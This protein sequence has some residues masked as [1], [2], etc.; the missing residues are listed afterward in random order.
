MMEAMSYNLVKCSS[1]GVVYITPSKNEPFTNIY[2]T[3]NK[4]AWLTIEWLSDALFKYVRGH[5]QE[6][7]DLHP[8]NRGKVI[9]Y[10][11][12]IQSSRWHRSYLKTPVRNTRHT[13]NSYMY[14]GLD[15]YDDL[16]LPQKFQPFLDFL[17]ETQ[18]MDKFNQVISNWYA[19]G[20]DYIAAH[21]D[22]RVDMK[23]DADIAILTLCAR[24]EDVRDLQF[25]SKNL[26]DV[27]NRAIYKKLN[28]Q[29]P[30]G[31]I[32]K[33][34]GDTQLKFRHMVP[35]APHISGSRISLTFRKF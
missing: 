29:T 14:S 6:L 20:H 4:S 11:Q 17:N 35:K 12:E 28:I 30:N 25:I 32:I 27:E 9:L 10:D 23:P 33:M 15:F 26:K 18:E 22:C 3:E 1:H 16:S 2:L 13:K 31:C 5:Y 24:E 19:N 34:H 21:S 8:E 7:F